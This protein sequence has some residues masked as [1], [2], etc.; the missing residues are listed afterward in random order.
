MKT[1]LTFRPS[2]AKN[3][4]AA[5]ASF[6]ALGA[7]DAV[8]A[9]VSQADLYI[10]PSALVNVTTTG[11][12]SLPSV[13]RDAD[14]D[15]A[16]VWNGQG[17]GDSYGIFMRRYTPTGTRPGGE[18]LVNTT[19]GGAQS[20]PDVASDALGNTVV[21]WRQPGVDSEIRMQRFDSIGQKQG[22]EAQVNTATVGNQQ[23][24]AVTMDVDGDY[25]VVWETAIGNGD[26]GGQHTV[27]GQRF[28]KDGT[29]LGA[30]FAVTPS[31]TARNPDVAM[32]ANGDFAVVWEGARNTDP[33]GVFA[34]RFRVDG[35]PI[36]GE[37]RINGTTS[38]AQKNP[39]IGMAAD[40]RFVVAY[41]SPDSD[42]TG[43]NNILFT[44][45]RADGSFIGQ[46]T[47]VNSGSTAGNQA[48]PSVAVDALFG[49]IVGWDGA[50]PGDATGVF[51]KRYDVNGNTVDPIFRLHNAAVAGTKRNVALASDADGDI[52]AAWA[53]NG[54][55]DT[56]GVFR[57]RIR[58]ARE[59]DLSLGTTDDPGIVALGGEVRYS[60]T[61][62]NLTAPSTPTGFSVI[63]QA[64][65]LAY[66]GPVKATIPIGTTYLGGG[67]FGWDCPVP[68]GGN[69]VTCNRI[70]AGLLGPGQSYSGP[71]QIVLTYRAPTSPSSAG[72]A[73]A[74][75][76]KVEVENLDKV[77]LDNNEDVENTSVVCGASTIRFLTQNP[78]YGEGIGSGGRLTVIREGNLV[79]AA[80]VSVSTGSS[81]NFLAPRATPGADYN[82][83]PSVANLI[84]P[85]G[86][87]GERSFNVTILE[88]NRD[89]DFERFAVRLTNISPSQNAVTVSGSSTD[90]VIEDND[91]TPRVSFSL[92]TDSVSEG[93][94]A[95]TYL[96]QLIGEQGQ[97][98]S[99][100]RRITVPISLSG[101]ATPGGDYNT[102]NTPLVIEPGQS[103]VSRTITVIDDSTREPNETVVV[104]LGTPTNATV[105]P[106]PS[107][108]MTILAND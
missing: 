11:S 81:A 103:S 41:E 23:L 60:L 52:V 90:V 70:I 99:S 76:A 43:N 20:F 1:K 3:A 62:S 18:I 85:A 84:W 91:A 33:D 86:Q 107:F 32:E 50:G 25:V 95:R 31:N 13:A 104:S 19:I 69:V 57:Q 37:L 97:S 53:G 74:H 108:T 77:P 65:G 92:S 66:V 39:A 45:V 61:V 16:V 78:L 5:A 58:S 79:C 46:D 4:I 64:I 105:G 29:P 6:T 17:A 27:S 102:L 71:E 96:V 42:G 28:S 8:L 34:Q 9:A 15:Y 82:P 72:I 106:R 38:G 89:E 93:V 100:G 55:G 47:L 54:A 48:R 67:G 68:S 26:I 24:P 40:G 83:T 94:G 22:V 2:W 10:N 44:R 30:E 98:I 49:F 87:G 14:G 56:S 75:V 101:A 21:V 59:L 88:D 51:G 35:T 36:G 73:M 80:S 63:D 12:Q 7:S